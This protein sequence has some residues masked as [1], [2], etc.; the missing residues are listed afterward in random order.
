V[1]QIYSSQAAGRRCR[2]GTPLHTFAHLANIA[3]AT[4]NRLEWD[5]Q[6]ERFTNCDEANRLLH[7][8]Y[9]KSWTLG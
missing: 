3:L 8:A 1:W 5:A 2:G 4:R 9:H 6:A 7:C